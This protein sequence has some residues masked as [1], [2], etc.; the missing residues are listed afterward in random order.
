MDIL[1]ILNPQQRLAVTADPGPTLVLAGPGSGKTRVLTHRI[2]YLINNLGV[3]PYHI[4]AV[5]FT[6]KAA[7]EMESRLEKAAGA[8]SPGDLDGHISR[9]SAREFCAARPICCHLTRTYVIFDD[10]DQLTLVK[11]AIK[12]LNLDEKIYR[13]NSVHAAISTAKNNLIF[14]QNFDNED[15][16]R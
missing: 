3:R 11:R 8:R 10:D 4:L 1:S 9:A 16:P 14:P 15:I 5:T 2:A 7:R 6:N 13:P 12:E